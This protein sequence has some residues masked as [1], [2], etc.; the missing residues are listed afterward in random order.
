MTAPTEVYPTRL[1]PE[2]RDLLSVDVELT[3]ASPEAVAERLGCEPWCVEAA[4]EA[5]TMDGEVMA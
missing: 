4:L 5:L 2:L 3:K 1:L